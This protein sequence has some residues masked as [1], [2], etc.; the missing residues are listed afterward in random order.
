MR[1]PQDFDALQIEQIEQRSR[2]RGQVDVVDIQAD[3]R[4]QREIEV[5]L[6]DAPDVGDEARAVRLRLRGQEDAGCLC[7]HFVDAGLA[8]RLQHVAGDGGDGQRRFL[9]VFAAELRRDGDFF[10]L[11]GV[12]GLLRECAAAN[13]EQRQ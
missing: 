7:R 13:H 11:V 3:T 1:T 4:L 8:A 5:G 9:Q 2:Q 10:E 6:A 12:G